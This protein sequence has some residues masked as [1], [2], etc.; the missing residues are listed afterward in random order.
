MQNQFSTLL[1]DP[2]NQTQQQAVVSAA[3][4]LAQGINRTSQAYTTQRQTAQD[5]IVGDVG[6]INS[7]LATIG[8]LSNQ[9]VALK[10]GGQSTADLEIQRD[11][12][13]QSLAQIVAVSTLVQP[14]GDMVITTAG[15]LA[16]PIHGAPNPLSTD[17]A[18][19]QPANYYPGGGVPPIMLGGVRRNR[20]AH[21]RAAWRQHHAARHDAADLPGRARR[22]L[23]EPRQPV[24]RAG[25]DA[26]LRSDRAMSGGGGVPAQ[27]QLCRL[28]RMSFR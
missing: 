8:Q 7:T 6:T 28:R 26:V 25:S 13:V 20:A 15:G 14:N 10:A 18:N 16:L 17:P 21:R 3:N 22:I 1:N 2:G 11:G 27:Q 12:A 24:R 23:A 19:L 9:I 5:N 4:T